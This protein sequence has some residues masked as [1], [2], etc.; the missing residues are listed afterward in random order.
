[1]MDCVYN[2]TLKAPYTKDKVKN[3]PT[4]YSEGGGEGK[5]DGCE[6]GE[7][8]MKKRGEGG[9]QGWTLTL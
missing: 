9:V 8:G 1:M 7:E 5:E 6:E 2:P 4:F 3:P